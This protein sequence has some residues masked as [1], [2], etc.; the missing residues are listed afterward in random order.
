MKSDVMEFFQSSDN[1]TV[2]ELFMGTI[3]SNMER[4]IERGAWVYVAGDEVVLRVATKGNLPDG[5]CVLF[6]PDSKPA[7]I[8]R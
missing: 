4:K 2:L 5:E 3:F 7:L 8:G 1:P 6:Y